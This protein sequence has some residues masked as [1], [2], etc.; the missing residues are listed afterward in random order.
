[1]LIF[2]AMTKKKRKPEMFYFLSTLV[3]PG[4]RTVYGTPFPS[5]PLFSIPL[6]F[7]FCSACFAVVL[8]TGQDG[9]H[10]EQAQGAVFAASRHG[11]QRDHLRHNQEGCG[12]A[13]GRSEETKVYST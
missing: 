11:W 9:K 4:K 8:W 3:V 13:Y 6:L 10:A 1:M 2:S 7:C 12:A 5:L